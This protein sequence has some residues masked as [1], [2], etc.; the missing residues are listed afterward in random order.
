MRASYTFILRIFVD[1]Q[2]PAALR[3]SLKLVSQDQ[4]LPFTDE[5]ML[6]DLLHQILSQEQAG[7]AQPPGGSQAEP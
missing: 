4:P 6:L 5:H 7:E 3:G 2:E 1:T